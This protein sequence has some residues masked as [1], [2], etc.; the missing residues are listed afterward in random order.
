MARFFGLTATPTAAAS[1]SGR[2]QTNAGRGVPNVI[3]TLEGG[4]LEEPRYVRTNSF[5]YCRFTDAPTGASYFLTINSKRYAF[6]SPNFFVNL[7]D[8]FEEAILSPNDGNKT[9]LLEEMFEG[10]EE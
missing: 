10:N 7:T 2:V 4:D 9:M 5:G 1:I 8:D 3:V 6:S